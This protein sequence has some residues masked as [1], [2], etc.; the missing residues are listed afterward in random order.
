MIWVI[1]VDFIEGVI[2]RKFSEV[3]NMV[4]K[5]KEDPNEVKE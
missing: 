1:K 4:K 2:L 3:E 5:G